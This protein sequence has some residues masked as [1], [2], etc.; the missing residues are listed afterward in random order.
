LLLERDG[1]VIAAGY[2][3]VGEQHVLVARYR[4]NGTLDPSFGSAGVARFGYLD[5]EPYAGCFAAA[6]QRDGKIVL[7][8]GN[9]GDIMLARL[10]S[11]GH[12]DRSF[13]GTGVVSL[14]RPGGDYAS[15]L[16]L[17][18]GALIAAG[19]TRANPLR[20]GSAMIA[21]RVTAMGRVGTT[22]AALHAQR[23]GST[24][25]LTWRTKREVDLKGFYVAV[26]DGFGAKLRRLARPLL[27]ARGS[28]TRGVAYST[29]VAAGP[30]PTSLT[31][32][33]YWVVEVSTNGVRRF[34]GP[35]AAGA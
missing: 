11:A 30:P 6:L 21:V 18:G 4:A 8:G 34:R 15:G 10:T 3:E 20:E 31:P 5:G 1:Q 33:L 9:G 22:Y 23:R 29:L 32:R 2:T 25:R 35:V 14:A 16:A 24:L 19:D 27:A 17:Q 26:G 12:L 13:G 28:P 7:A